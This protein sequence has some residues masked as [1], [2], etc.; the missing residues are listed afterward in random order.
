MASLIRDAVRLPA[1]LLDGLFEHPLWKYEHTYIL[2][3]FSDIHTSILWLHE[4]A[5]GVE[6]DHRAA[7]AAAQD[8]RVLMAGG[9]RAGL[10]V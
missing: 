10:L 8:D 5:G 6:Q 3:L 1:A 9:K 2:P 4:H 7:L